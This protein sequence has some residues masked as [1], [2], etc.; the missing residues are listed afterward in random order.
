[1]TGEKKIKI[2]CK[3]CNVSKTC[4]IVSQE[5]TDHQG[6]YGIDS[7]MMAKVKIHKHYKAKNHCKGSDRTVIVPLDKILKDNE[8]N[9]D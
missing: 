1:M 5:T 8:K 3:W 9:R 7:V 4:H 6:Q 2:L